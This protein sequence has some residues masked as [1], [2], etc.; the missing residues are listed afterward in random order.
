[1][2][3][4]IKQSIYRFRN[5]NPDIFKEKYLEYLM[6]KIKNIKDE[7]IMEYTSKDQNKEQYIGN[8]IINM[9]NKCYH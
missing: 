1:M 2:V 3:G 7:I 8:P 9:D 4:D 6:C 5:A